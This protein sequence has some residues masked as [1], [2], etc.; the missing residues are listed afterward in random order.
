MPGATSD[1]PYTALQE[2]ARKIARRSGGRMGAPARRILE[3]G[4]VS[5]IDG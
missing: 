1:Y 3:T 5:N 2:D 4:V